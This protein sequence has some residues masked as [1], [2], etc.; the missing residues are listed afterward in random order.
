MQPHDRGGGKEV[1]A[2]FVWHSTGRRPLSHKERIEL[3]KLRR[4]LLG[5][6]G[7]DKDAFIQRA[8]FVDLAEV[9]LQLGQDVPDLDFGRTAE[10]LLL[11]GV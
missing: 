3:L 2:E 8:M 11:E 6:L 5:D 10:Q 7:K 4:C 1:V 9:S